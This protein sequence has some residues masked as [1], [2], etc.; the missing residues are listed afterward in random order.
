MDHETGTSRTRQASTR[1]QTP[2]VSERRQF[3]RMQAFEDAI[4]Y[5]RARVAAPC[6]DCV[7][8]ETGRQCDDHARDVEL[9]DEYADEIERSV[10]AIDAHAA[11]TVA[12]PELAS[13]A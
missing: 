8:A 9:I 4:A 1:R 12:G 5:R 10:R 13:S 11:G 2:G 6:T 7:A 3:R